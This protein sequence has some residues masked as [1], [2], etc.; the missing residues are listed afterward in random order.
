MKKLL[1]FIAL[2]FIPV[3]VLAAPNIGIDSARGI[4]TQSGFAN[5]NEYTLSETIGRYIQIALTMVGTIFIA[6][7]VY[8]GFLWM[9]ASGNEDQ[10]AKAKEIIKMATMGLVVVLAAYSITYFVIGKVGGATQGGS[11]QVGSDGSPS[12]AWENLPK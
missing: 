6:L 3:A 2:A 11:A 7:T 5:A 1:L 8:A 12:N 9:T 4:A 10:V